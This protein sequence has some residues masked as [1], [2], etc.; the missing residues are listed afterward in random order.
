MIII[1][2]NKSKHLIFKG[3]DLQRDSATT[4]NARFPSE[5]EVSGTTSKCLSE[6]EICVKKAC[7][8]LS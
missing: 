5:D 1:N 2:R 6:I 8:H 4:E 7:L 3:N